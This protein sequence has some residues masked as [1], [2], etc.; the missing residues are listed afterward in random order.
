MPTFERLYL[1]NNIYTTNKCTPHENGLI[2]QENTEY[3]TPHLEMSAYTCIFS[4][5]E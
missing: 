3:T 4:V 1:E 2:V 5:F